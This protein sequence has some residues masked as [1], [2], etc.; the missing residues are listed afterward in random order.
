M[1]V[2]SLKES[3][4]V[5]NGQEWSRTLAD[6]IKS[7]KNS[8]PALKTVCPALQHHQ[9]PVAASATSCHLM[10][11]DSVAQVT[12]R[13]EEFAPSHWL[14]CRNF[15]R[16]TAHELPISLHA[17]SYAFASPLSAILKNL[18]ETINSKDRR[19]GKCVR[20]KCGKKELMEQRILTTQKPVTKIIH[21]ICVMIPFW[22]ISRIKKNLLW[23]IWM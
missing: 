10:S 7:H 22:Q 13:V 5:Q 15:G 1:W 11:Q 2:A 3:T 16:Q 14:I 18:E 12:C 4:S 17:A 8:V 23:Q 21:E 20:Y 6:T 19:T 9:G